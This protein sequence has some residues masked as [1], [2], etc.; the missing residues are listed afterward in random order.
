MRIGLELYN[1]DRKM[2]WHELEA[3]TTVVGSNP[4]CDLS[5]PDPQVAPVQCVLNLTQG[6]L[7]LHNS[8]ADGTSVSGEVV[9]DEMRLANQDEIQLGPIRARII[10]IEEPQK[11]RATRTLSLDKAA[12]ESELILRLDATGQTYE[13]GEAGLSVGGDAANDV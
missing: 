9:Q 6:I 5:V 3:G 2:L 7:T 4:E 1:Q 11:E 10:Y 8:D 12:S 13:L